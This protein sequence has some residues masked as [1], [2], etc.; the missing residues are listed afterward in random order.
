M[1]RCWTVRL[2]WKADILLLPL[3]LLE[4]QPELS[5]KQDCHAANKET[6]AKGVPVV[7]RE[8]NVIVKNEATPEHSK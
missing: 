1:R 5:E 7:T 3:G 2:G 6:L 4:S 8:A